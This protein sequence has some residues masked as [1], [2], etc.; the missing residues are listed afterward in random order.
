MK[1]FYWLVKREFWEHRGGFLWAPVITGLIIL[2]FNIMAIITG[3]VFRSR[4]NVHI[5]GI[6]MNAFNQHMSADAMHT[7]GKVLDAGMMLPATLI[8]LTLFVVVFFYCIHSL[9]DDRRD[10]SILF[11]K[12]LPIS[13]LSTVLSKVFCATILAPAI[14]IIV[15]VAVGWCILLLMAIAGAFHSISLWHLLWTLPHPFHF[16][17]M[18]L[19]TLPIYVLWSLP[20]VGWLMLCSAAARG[21][22]TRWAIALP[23]GVGVLI[24]WFN[25]MNVFNL[26]SLWYWQN[27]AGRS[28]FSVMPGSWIFAS[29][30]SVLNFASGFAS[31]FAGGEAAGESAGK[32]AADAFFNLHDNYALVFTAPFLVGIAVG[33]VLLGAAIWIRRSRTDM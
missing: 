14:A 13:D 6:D 21:K 11:W 31:G 18:M 12:S 3:E 33:I 25:I 15:S 23:V 26:S 24:G 5:N 9:W 28:L 29:K 16:V 20:C 27:I 7:L 10:R 32:H 17:A 2:A 30:G 8:G 1:T 4:A 19:G 22:P